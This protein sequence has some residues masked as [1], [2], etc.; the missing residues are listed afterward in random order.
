MK[1]KRA[2][3]RITATHVGGTRVCFKWPCGHFRTE[4]LAKRPLARRVP[5]EAGVKFLVRYW[6]D[7]LT[8]EPCPQCNRKRR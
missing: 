1:P 4:D 3:T 6:R 7:G 2:D 8:G 5:T